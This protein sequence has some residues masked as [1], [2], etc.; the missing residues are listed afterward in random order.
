MGFFHRFA[1]KRASHTRFWAIFMDEVTPHAV[2]PA[3]APPMTTDLVVALD[4][5][6]VEDHT[7]YMFLREYSAPGEPLHLIVWDGASYREVA[8]RP[9]GRR[10]GTELVDFKAPP[11]R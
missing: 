8:A 3:S 6:R 9:S 11:A 2:S 4:G 1:L 7:Q 10:F 5:F